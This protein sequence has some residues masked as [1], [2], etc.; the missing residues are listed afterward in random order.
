[1]LVLLLKCGTLP[2]LSRLGIGA[3]HVVAFE[4]GEGLDEGMIII[5][6]FG[7]RHDAVFDVTFAECSRPC[8]SR[9]IPMPLFNDD[10]RSLKRVV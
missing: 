5:V 2:H 10:L 3:R 4:A 1:M 7:Y 8:F 6:P 9:S